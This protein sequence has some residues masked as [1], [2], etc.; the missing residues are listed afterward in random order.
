MK[1]VAKKRTEFHTY[2]LTEERSYRV[3][4]TIMQYSNNPQETI[5]ETQ[6]LGHKVTNIWIIK[7]YRTKQPL[8]MFFFCMTEACPE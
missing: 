1:A 7:Q 3:V 8:F 2:R 5:N 4:L 6:K